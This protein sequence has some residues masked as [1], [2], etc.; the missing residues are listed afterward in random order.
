MADLLLGLVLG[1][2]AAMALPMLANGLLSVKRPPRVNI[3]QERH[4]VNTCRPVI[5][6]LAPVPY[7]GGRVRAL[8]IGINYTG[9]GN[10]LRGCVNDVRSMLGTLQQIQFPIS[11]C[12]ILVDDP[13]FPNFTA[14]PTRDNIIKYM[15]WLTHD[16]RPGDVLF[17]HYSGHG[18]QTKAANDS[19]EEYDQTLIPL[20]HHKS[21]SILD[22][23][24]FLMLVAPL[25]PGVRMTVVFDCCHS[26]TMLDMPFSYIAPRHSGTREQMVQVRRNNY[27]NGDVIMFSGCTDQGTSADVRSGGGAAN[28]AATLAFTWS[29]LHTK[30]FS[31]LNILLKTREE[32][33]KQGREQVPQLTSSKPI[34]LYKPFSLFGMLTV[35]QT[36]MSQCVPQQYQRPPPNMPPQMLPPQQGGYPA[37]M[38]PPPQGFPQWGSPQP[39][40]GGRPQYPPPPN[41]QGQYHTGP[42]PP[43]WRPPPPSRPPYNNNAPPAQYSCNPNP[44][45][46]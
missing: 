19:E 21:G 32:L 44:P 9:T 46:W 7:T 34:D 28:G 18:G 41:G 6:Y 38:P 24:L 37:Y 45:A 5:P 29:L 40:L 22:D 16:L 11:E 20:D 39:Q 8:F 13:K 25:P 15:L 33:R 36:M 14:L 4:K 3:N 10:E 30:G 43:G 35:N 2:V 12:C 23:D 31:Y 1:Q 27:S 17:L 26:A 42:P